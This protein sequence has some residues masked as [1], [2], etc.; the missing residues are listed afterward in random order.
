MRKNFE[1]IFAEYNSKPRSVEQNISPCDFI[2]LIDYLHKK[3]E[4]KPNGRASIVNV[5]PII[6]SMRCFEFGYISC[7]H[8]MKYQAK[9]N[10]KN[11]ANTAK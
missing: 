7:I 2:D 4:G 6:L 1:K 8:S 10:K 9:R 3:Y 11:K 5:D